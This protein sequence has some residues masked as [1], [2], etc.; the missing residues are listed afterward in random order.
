L[1]RSHSWVNSLQNPI[2]KKPITKE[3]TVGVAQ[4]V[5]HLPSKC[6]ALHSTPLPKKKKNSK[7]RVMVYSCNLSYSRGRGRRIKLSR[8]ACTVSETLPQKQTNE[9]G[10]SS[11]RALAK[12]FELLGFISSNTERHT[13]AGTHKHRG[14][15]TCH[16]TYPPSIVLGVS[17]LGSVSSSNS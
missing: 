8:S 12:M 13:H 3:K 15:L 9:R 11:G 7:L 2:W 4:V 10:D 17:H 5:E 16:L 14:P 6:K 1:I